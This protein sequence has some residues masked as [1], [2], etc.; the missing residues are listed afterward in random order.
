MTTNI[1]YLMRGLPGCGKSHMANRP[2][3]RSPRRQ[4]QNRPPSPR[5]N[6]PQLDEPLE[7]RPDSRRDLSGVVHAVGRSRSLARP[8]SNAA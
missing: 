2:M 4:N 3:G 5:L 6:N 8:Q 1:V 7:A